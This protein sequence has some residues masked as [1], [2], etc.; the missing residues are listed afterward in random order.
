MTKGGKIVDFVAIETHNYSR[1]GVAWKKGAKLLAVMS[2]RIQ[3]RCLAQTGA[4]MSQHHPIQ[5]KRQHA[6]EG[7][8]GSLARTNYGCQAMR[9]HKHIARAGRG[10]GALVVASGSEDVDADV[11]PTSEK[12]TATRCRQKCQ[13]TDV[14]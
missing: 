12:S 5:S 8:A 10:A 4:Q 7:I 13:M 9:N 2:N 3:Q 11:L 14:D 6:G 1:V